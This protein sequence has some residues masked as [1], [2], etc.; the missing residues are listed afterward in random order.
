MTAPTIEDTARESPDD[1]LYSADTLYDTLKAAA[2]TTDPI[3]RIRAAQA[4]A[5]VA[6][7]NGKWARA[8][9]D[10]ATVSAHNDFAVEPVTLYRDIIGVSRGLYNRMQQRA[11]R[12]S[13]RAAIQ[14]VMAMTGHDVK[15]G[16]DMCAVAGAAAHA[17]RVYKDIA[18]KA[19][20]IRDETGRAVM[21]GDHGDP[22]P[23]ADFA[24]ATGLTTAR[25][26]QIRLGTSGHSNPSVA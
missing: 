24:R 11:N 1:V 18:T 23:N 4:L 25:A 10:N 15:T 3:Q 5:R 17:A 20:Q 12:R 22:M 16:D 7:R 19:R 13:P 2:D 21:D 8:L 9:R 26:A 6:V 14:K